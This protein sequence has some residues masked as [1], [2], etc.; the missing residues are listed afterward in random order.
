MGYRDNYLTPVQ[1]S[2]GDRSQ[3]MALV[4]A[5]MICLF[6]LL[7]VQFLLLGVGVEGY[8]GKESSVVLP[9]CAASGL[10]CAAAC[11]LIGYVA[12]PR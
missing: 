4:Y 10:C 5:A 9:A 2:A 3:K 11:K 7:F 1:P 6:V 8:L 12:S